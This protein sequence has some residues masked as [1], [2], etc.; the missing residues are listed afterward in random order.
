[1]LGPPKVR[2]LDH[3][4]L[5]SLEAWVPRD[6][7][8]RQLERKLDLSFIREWVKESYTDIG[9][10][11]IDPVVLFKLQ[12]VLYA[13]GMGRAASCRGQ[14]VARASPVPAEAA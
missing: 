5:V 8:Y 1:M 7:L 6:E 9:R 12:L 2:A 13:E 11:S 3:P 10:P 4:V 14:D